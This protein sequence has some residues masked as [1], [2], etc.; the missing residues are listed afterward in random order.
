MIFNKNPENMF[1]AVFNV[2]QGAVMT[3][4]VSLYLG[5]ADAVSLLRT[6]VCAYCA[7]VMLTAFVR[8]PAFGAW[9]A[10]VLRCRGKVSGYL[11]S[12]GAGGM[13]MGVLMNFFITFMQIGPVPYFPAAFMHTLLFSMVVS[14]VSSCLWIGPVNVLVGRV[15]AKT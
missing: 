15:Y 5:Q 13:L 1:N 8:I 14:A 9:A 3:V 6:F 12:A 4:A 2:P 10:R 11:V 7:G